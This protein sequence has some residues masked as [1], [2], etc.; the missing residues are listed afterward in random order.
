MPKK[1]SETSKEIAED[2]SKEQQ[3]SINNFI[4]TEQ[5][6]IN[7]LKTRVVEDKNADMPQ[8]NSYPKYIYADNFDP[9]NIKNM[10]GDNLIIISGPIK[11]TKGGIPSLDGK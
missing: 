6:D 5:F 3:Q 8:M 7:R 11:M 2:D 10:D 1:S 4:T 9:K